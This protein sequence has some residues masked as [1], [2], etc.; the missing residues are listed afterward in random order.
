M[1]PDVEERAMSYVEPSPPNTTTF[2]SSALGN[3]PLAIN[4]SK[5]S[6]TPCA[7]AGADAMVVYSHEPLNGVKG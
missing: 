6:L 5:A 3:C 2:R 1:A 7:P 4:T